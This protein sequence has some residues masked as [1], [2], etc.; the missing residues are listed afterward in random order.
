MIPAADGLECEAGFSR[1]P[2]RGGDLWPAFVEFVVS[3]HRLVL[4]ESLH[5]GIS[6]R[7]GYLEALFEQPLEGGLW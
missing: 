6:S 2:E 7:Q 4:K 5:L 3:W 1:A